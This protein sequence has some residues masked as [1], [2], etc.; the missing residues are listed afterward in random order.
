MLSE[1]LQGYLVSC[2]PSYT[3]IS[4]IRRRGAIG[5]YAVLCCRRF[6]LNT[7][8][9]DLNLWDEGGKRAPPLHHASTPR[10]GIRAVPSHWHVERPDSVDCW[11][12]STRRG[13][14]HLAAHTLIW[15]S[16]S[17]AIGRPTPHAGSRDVSKLARVRDLKHS[18]FGRGGD[19]RKPSGQGA[20][21]SEAFGVLLIRAANRTAQQAAH[22]MLG[23][24]LSLRSDIIRHVWAR[25]AY[26]TEHD[27]G[28]LRWTK[29]QPEE[30]CCRRVGSNKRQAG[31]DHRRTRAALWEP[32]NIQ[33]SGTAGD[34]G[35]SCL[36]LTTEQ[37]RAWRKEWRKS[38]DV[39]PCGLQALMLLDSG[40][41][42][43]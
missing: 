34:G 11:L 10:R 20:N 22:P 29:P 41:G 5:P 31:S 38:Q 2:S 23:A 42:D 21:A 24:G 12:L 6:T 8:L 27:D 40:C 39:V 28:A 15:T 30:T 32:A 1:G 26:A 37:R 3:S 7:L 18:P 43:A 33:G 4:L 14:C 17:V 19:R 35:R 36:G 9:K 16:E 25:P 13:L